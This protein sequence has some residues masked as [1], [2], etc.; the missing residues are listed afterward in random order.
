MDVGDIAYIKVK[1]GPEPV[2]YYYYRSSLDDSRFDPCILVRPEDVTIVKK[3][4]LVYIRESTPSPF[5]LGPSSWWYNE[6]NDDWDSIE[7]D[8]EGRWQWTSTPGQECRQPNVWHCHL[9][10]QAK[11]MECSCG[12]DMY[13]GVFAQRMLEPHEYQCVHKQQDPAFQCRACKNE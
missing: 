4:D 6:N 13:G 11:V 7:R 10:G 5:A 9:C 1:K 8:P 12:Y 2:Y 3:S